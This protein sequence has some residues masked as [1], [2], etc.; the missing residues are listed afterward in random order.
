MKRLL[1]LF[2]LPLFVLNGL[3]AQPE[4]Q[5]ETSK[6]LDIYFTLFKTL[7]L[8]YVDDISATRLTKTAIDAMLASLDPYTNYIPENEI[9][10]YRFMTTGEYGGIGALIHR[11]NGYIYIS[12]I[13]ENSPAHK[14]GLRPGDKILQINNIEANG[15]NAD[16]LNNLMKGEPGSTVTV[17]VERL[18]ANQPLSFVLKREKIKPDNITF[19]GMVSTNTG[20][21]RLE[22]FTENSADEFRQAFIKLKENPEMANLIIDLRGNGGGLL[23]EAVSI[24]NLFVKKGTPI[25]SVK[26]RIPD[27][28][29]DYSTIF[30]PIDTE[31][32]II[33]L[34]D[35][36]SAS[37][38][39]ILAGALQDL[40]RAVIYGSKSFGKGLVQNVLPLT[41]NTQLKIT[42]AKYYIPSGRC[43]QAI[44]YSGKSKYGTSNL[45]PDSLKST[46]YTRNS[47][48]VFDGGGIE[49]DLKSKSLKPSELLENL[50]SKYM[51][52][53]FATQYALD[54]KTI[55]AADSFDISNEDYTAFANYLKSINFTYKS[56]TE[57]DLGKLEE[58]LKEHGHPELIESY[59]KPIQDKLKHNLQD[60]LLQEK[61]EILPVL[62]TEIVGRYH[63]Q[64]GKV[65]NFIRHD[66]E[67]KE[68]DKILND[69]ELYSKVLEGTH[70]DAL[71]KKKI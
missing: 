44:D 45:I 39:E 26:S 58:D 16:D 57:D 1:L 55:A 42:V 54:H 38:S 71:N 66:H 13:L 10:D 22:K 9:D 15:R 23:T 70:P 43:I 12:D 49:P 40:D 41:Y 21:I 61:N 56:K 60:E 68:A 69:K 65:R 17:I 47:R 53:D 8:N 37:A 25:V 32:P 51:V 20:Y 46:F 18:K 62:R 67:I 35:G 59:L 33:V 30:D 36:N 6:N 63:Y 27:R 29:R 19:S 34:T 7:S 3:K 11:N 50:V 5:F 31:I 4:G 14:S 2:I 48:K 28:N 52:F 64:K 24:A